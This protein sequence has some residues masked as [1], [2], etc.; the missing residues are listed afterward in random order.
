MIGQT[1]IGSIEIEP[2]VFG[3]CPEIPVPFDQKTM[4]VAKVVVERVA[5]AELA[6]IVEE[7][8]IAGVIQFVVKKIAVIFFRWRGR[9]LELV[10]RGSGN[11]GCG[12]TENKADKEPSYLFHRSR[13]LGY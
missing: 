4:R 8:A 3:P 12:G 11:E 5:V 2:L 10:R 6:V 7:A 13:R 1:V 9:R